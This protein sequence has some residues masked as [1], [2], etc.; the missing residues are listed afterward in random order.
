MDLIMMYGKVTIHKKFKKIVVCSKYVINYYYICSN[1]AFM[2]RHFIHLFQT[3]LYFIVES[4]ITAIFVFIAWTFFLKKYFTIDIQ[5]ID[6]IFGIFVIKIILSNV[7]AT[8]LEL[9]KK[10]ENKN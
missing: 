2:V 7:Y 5:F 1:Y 4:S 8:V 3:L 10:Y 9:D 6:F